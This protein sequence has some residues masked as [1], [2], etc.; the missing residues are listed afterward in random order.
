MHFAT[1]TNMMSHVIVSGRQRC[2]L[3]ILVREQFIKSSAIRLVLFFFSF[4]NS[5]Q[6]T[7]SPYLDSLS[8][9]MK[10]KWLK[11]VVLN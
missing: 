5:C 4:F 6:Q 10:E 8:A 9:V 3:F 1:K 2:Y 11:L 7:T